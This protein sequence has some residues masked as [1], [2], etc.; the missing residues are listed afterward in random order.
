MSHSRADLACNQ[1][2]EM[3][4]DYLEGDLS[5]DER[6]QLEQHLVIC[7]PC[8]HYIDQSRLTVEALRRLPR[9][10]VAPAA[11]NALLEAFRKLRDEEKP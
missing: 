2:V 8:V 9:D 7:D 6:A 1:V 4:T 3:V 5:A 11:R 10:P